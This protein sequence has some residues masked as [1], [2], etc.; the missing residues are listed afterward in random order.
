MGYALC[1]GA[2]PTRD[3]RHA[4]L[5]RFNL[6]PALPASRLVGDWFSFVYTLD[7][8]HIK[9]TAPVS[10]YCDCPLC[11]RY[12]LGYLHHL[13]KVKDTLSL[14]LATLHNLRF[15]AQLT[16]HLRSQPHG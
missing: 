9:S 5:Y 1:D 16:A 2:M 10:P 7:D 4:R 8:K 15:M 14:R 6:D 12:S 11:T 3:A 13:F